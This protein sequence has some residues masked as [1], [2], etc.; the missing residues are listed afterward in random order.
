MS[1]V[2]ATDSGGVRTLTICRPEVKNA[3]SRGVIDTLLASLREAGLS[4]DVGVVV[5]TGA[6]DT[7]SSGA[8]LREV[9]SGRPATAAHLATGSLMPLFQL[10]EEIRACPLT[11]V[12]AVNG[13][14]VGGG[15]S[16]AMACDLVVAS[17]QASFWLPEVAHSLV[18]VGPVTELVELVGRQR[19]FDLL[20]NG[21]RLT[22]EEA[23]SLGLV[24]RVSP[25]ATFA[26]DWRQ[27]AADIA[28]K[29]RL[30]LALTKRL[31][32]RAADRNRAELLE[33]ASDTYAIS[34]LAGSSASPP[35]SS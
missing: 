20:A 18:P 1:S 15:F 8:D 13:A 35:N 5:L 25:A 34:K 17:D 16:L 30:T 26:D 29:D 23:R 21:V 28:G 27:F 3:L 4:G 11:I 24:C 19:A 12:A 10:R 31:L 14:A 2:T 7:F 33:A 22:A 6:D 32:R 9:R